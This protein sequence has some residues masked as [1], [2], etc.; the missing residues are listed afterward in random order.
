MTGSGLDLN[1]VVALLESR[2][3]QYLDDLRLLVSIDSG[4]FDK[5]GV[6]RVVDVLERWYS[7]L[8]ASVDRRA[9][10][11]YGDILTA[12]FPG[13]GPGS[14]LL[15]GHTDTVYA[16]GTVEARPMRIAGDRITGPGTA[17][18]KSGDLSI[19]Y[20]L[21][22]L[23]DQGPE[24]PTS[25]VVLHNPDEEIGSPSSK[26][27][28]A[29]L[30]RGADAVLVLEPGRANG[31]VVVARKGIMDIQVWA[32]GRAAHAGVNHDEGR[33]AVLAMAHLVAAVEALNGTLPDLT[34]NVGRIEGGDRSN[35]VP[36]R[37]YAR[38]E[39]RAFDRDILEQA[40]EHIRRLVE[41]PSVEGTAMRMEVSVEH[42]P[43][44]RSDAGG[45][46]YALA[47]GIAGSLGI[48]LGATATGGA[49]DGNTAAAA[50]LPVLDGL[51]PVGGRAHSPDE[52]IELSSVVP[53]TALLTGLV[54]ALGHPDLR[55]PQRA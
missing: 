19:V 45:R 40:A 31:D 48:D 32:E 22:A 44:H 35:V 1:R 14:V 37:A 20:A 15:I 16:S 36:D 6:N 23:L 25:V 11:V 49:S 38:L 27:V 50:G 10:D 53:R 18:M 43:M 13:K 21:R 8:G 42:W 17:D 9:G 30:A 41:T 33:S 52:Y 28:V 47:R 24:L 2:L 39:I 29:E 5:D 54:A 12:T 55:D 51:G 26:G 4:T 46:L 34:A 3:P 7:D